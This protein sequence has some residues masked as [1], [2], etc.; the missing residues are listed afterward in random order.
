[1]PLKM[2]DIPLSRSSI[3]NKE[4]YY[5][6]YN[7]IISPCV[8]S[9]LW[10]PLGTALGCV[11]S[12]PIH[13]VLLISR[14]LSRIPFGVAYTQSV[15]TVLWIIL[16][17]LLLVL[18]LILK[19]KNPAWLFGALTAMYILSSI[20]TWAEPRL[21]NV[22][23]TVL[24]VGQGQC[25]LL[26]SKDGAFLID[27]GG[28]N[29]KDVA[30]RALQT[31]GAQGITS[32]DG[33]IL[34]HYDEDHANGIPYLCDVFPVTQLYLPASD[35]ENPIRLR[36]EGKEDIVWVRNNTELSCGVGKIV[37]YPS[38]NETSGNESSMCILFQG[39]NCDILITGDRDIE[40]EHRLLEQGNIPELDVL[41]VGHHG[42]ETSTGLE[43]LHQTKPKIAVV[44]V[45][46]HNYHG[47]PDLSV[48]RRLKNA[49]CLIYRTDLEGTI[50][51][52]G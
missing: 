9:V 4:D 25:V 41:V 31:L 26:Q 30:E 39:E 37:I 52:R 48:L 19:K 15:Y 27:C 5:A 13:Y 47:H 2:Q 43:L 20:A 36:L 29:G 32:L 50:V 3:I 28:S 12:L 7:S 34:T 23:V 10:V 1:M 38:K 14:L 40:G 45:G 22:R 11:V 18:F 6:K 21:D 51:I 24:D 33:L 17:G 46:K 44:S 42:A 16:S 49:G 8:L 35:R